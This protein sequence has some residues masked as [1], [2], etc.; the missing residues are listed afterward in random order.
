MET[1]GSDTGNETGHKRFFGIELARLLSEKIIAQDPN[2]PAQAFLADTEASG[3]TELELLDRVDTLAHLLRKH[4]PQHYPDALEQLARIY[5]PENPN[6]TGMFTFGYWLWPV[7]SFI[8]TYGLDHPNES[9]AAIKELTKR[10][11]GEFA[12]RPYIAARPT[13]TVEVMRGWT[14]SSNVHIRRLASE[15]LRPRL[16]WS[17][18]LTL[19]ITE[20]QPIFEVLDTLKDD[21][22]RFVQKSVANNLN[23]YLKGN[24]TDT[25]DLLIRWAANP[26]PQRQWIIRHA[27]RNELRRGSTDAQN[28]LKHAL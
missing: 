27:L 28:I 19:F 14:T 11:T 13:E 5:G 9:I 6:E 4:L 25:L 26:T 24:R 1:L 21:T 8:A 3:L 16:P 18:R 12:I 15:G 10:H 17:K 22:S 20:P 23:D 7:G 2:F